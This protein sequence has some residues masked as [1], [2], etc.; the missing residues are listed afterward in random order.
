M[1]DSSANRATFI[2]SAITFCRT[3]GFD[4]VDLDW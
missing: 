1:A 4:G 3:H 2:Q